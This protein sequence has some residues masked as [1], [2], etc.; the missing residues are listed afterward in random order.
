MA[1]VLVLRPETAARRTA[2]RLGERGHA[3]VIAP[4]LTIHS[5]D[6]PRP[7]GAFDGVVVTSPN[8]FEALGEGDVAALAALPLLAVGERTGE[9]AREAG[10]AAVMAAAGD[11][12][13]LAALAPSVFPAG[14]R[15]LLV[16]GRDHKADTPALL[17][18]AGFAVVPWIAYVAEAEESL[19]PAAV[20][21]LGGGNVTVAL[22][23]SR[24]SAALALNLAER[25]GCG[26]AFRALRHLCL[27]E[28]VAA[29]LRAAGIRR[30]AAAA[31][32]HEEALLAL[33]PAHG[34]R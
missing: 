27:S 15:L 23:Y 19:P 31:A 1:G 22:H 21:A 13:A 32:P 25:A 14:A 12:I 7:A 4:L 10:F 26:E 3:V 18:A 8:A 30:V 9:A 2:Q 34:D 16:L 6:E 28:D 29:P 20:V 11:R 24:R 5:T 17:A 33:L